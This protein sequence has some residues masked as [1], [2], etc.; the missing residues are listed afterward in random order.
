MSP[1]RAAGSRAAGSRAAGSRDRA[2][3]VAPFSLL[4][5]SC[6]GSHHINSKLRNKTSFLGTKFCMEKEN[7]TY[8]ISVCDKKGH[9]YTDINM[10]Q[11]C[12]HIQFQEKKMRGSKS[13][14]RK[15]TFL[16]LR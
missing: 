12:F 8:Y 9:T 2:S 15:N 13:Q 3:V 14:K 7:Y 11:F 4:H 1:N 5:G 6:I 16:W 10:E